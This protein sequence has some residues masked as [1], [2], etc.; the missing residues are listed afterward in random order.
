MNDKTY[1]DI[2]GTYVFDADHSRR[3]YQLNMLMMSLIKPENREEFKADEAAYLSKYELT[4]A[5][6]KAIR[7]DP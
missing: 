6:K 7:S 5:Q 2:P 1:K 4:E 3:G